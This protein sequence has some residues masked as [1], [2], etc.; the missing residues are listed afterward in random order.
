MHRVGLFHHV[1]LTSSTPWSPPLTSCHVSISA[2]P[3]SATCHQINLFSSFRVGQ[4]RHVSFQCRPFQV[5]TGMW[6]SISRDSLI[7]PTVQISSPIP[8]NL[9]RPIRFAW[10]FWLRGQSQRRGDLTRARVV[11]T[12]HT[13]ELRVWKKVD[14]G[15]VVRGVG[16]WGQV[17]GCMAERADGSR[18]T[19]F[20]LGSLSLLFMLIV[21]FGLM[22]YLS[23]WATQ[24]SNGLIVIFF[25]S[26]N[27]LFFIFYC[28]VMGPNLGF[29]NWAQSK[30]K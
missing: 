10:S 7:I 15:C 1:C 25:R 29:L 20:W 28:W 2:S 5:E 22:T 12:V 21:T 3:S 6:T 9:S 8:S 23:V 24:A 4:N 17:C 18:E 30:I 13:C 26:P 11:V 27:F 19:V 16:Q 14:R